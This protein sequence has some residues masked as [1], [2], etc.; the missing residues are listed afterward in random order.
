MIH[1]N[2]VPFTLFLVLVVRLQ[3]YKSPF[4]ELHLPKPHPQTPKLCAP[5]ERL[6]QKALVMLPI[7]QGRCP[8]PRKQWGNVLF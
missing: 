7:K 2:N 1:P 6:G 4:G 8:G 5:E 3:T